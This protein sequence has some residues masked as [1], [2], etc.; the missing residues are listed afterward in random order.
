MS[1]Q[2][3]PLMIGLLILVVAVFVIF[4]IISF[5]AHDS[6]WLNRGGA[7]ITAC[8]A[9]AVFFQIRLEIDIEKEKH[10]LKNSSYK[11]TRT[12][13]IS[14]IEEKAQNLMSNKTNHQDSRLNE[15]R[16]RIGAVVA[17]S[18]LI[19]ELLHGFG[20]FLLK[21]LFDSHFLH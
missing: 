11:A 12:Y 5:I 4:L 14:P 20:D 3:K 16:L 18:A 1:D 21:L 15:K 9:G 8:A 10:K 2:S 7:L 13:A 17:F 6:H 19:G